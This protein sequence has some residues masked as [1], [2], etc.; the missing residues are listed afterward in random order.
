MKEISPYRCGRKNLDFSS[1]KGAKHLFCQNIFGKWDKDDV[2]LA[3]KFVP[4][5]FMPHKVHM[6][7]QHEV[8]GHAALR[9]RHAG[10][11]GILMAISGLILWIESGILPSSDPVAMPQWLV[12]AAHLAHDFG[13]LVIIVFGLGHSYLG[14]GIFQPYKGTARL[15]WG[16]GK[17]SE[18]GAAYH[19]GYW[20]TTRLGTGKGVTEEKK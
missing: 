15:M 2:E 3:C 8:E 17:V 20:A 12:W 11:H 1:P 13:F 9:R 7:P 6:S 18:S 14:G 10:L 19:W 5:L 4:Y 16:D